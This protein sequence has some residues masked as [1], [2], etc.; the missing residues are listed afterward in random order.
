MT[1]D[2]HVGAADIGRRLFILPGET[3]QKIRMNR[4]TSTRTKK[5]Q[6][7]PL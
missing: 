3:K 7:R 4:T 2:D 6:P 5:K 1:V